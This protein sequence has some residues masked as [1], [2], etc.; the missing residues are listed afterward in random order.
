MN[1]IEYLDFTRNELIELG[2]SKLQ[3][4]HGYLVELL[5]EL[6]ER[7]CDEFDPEYN[8]M[9][10]LFYEIDYILYEYLNI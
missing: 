5:D 4:I 7:G 2:V 6:Y 10:E 3:K 9:A 1:I 8:E